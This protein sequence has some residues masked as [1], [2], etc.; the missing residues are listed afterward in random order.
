MIETVQKEVVDRTFL[1]ESDDSEE[2]KYGKQV[3]AKPMNLIRR[4]KEEHKYFLELAHADKEKLRKFIRMID[5]MT[6]QTLVKVNLQSMSILYEEMQ[7]DNRK[8]GGL[9][10]SMVRFDPDG[11]SF[12][13][14][15]KEI[16]E[17]LQGIL[18]DMIKV[19]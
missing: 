5:Y 13:P 16:A 9:F 11:I 6:I 3:K 19:A 18:T 2:A 4:Q 10:N 7:R 1:K 12:C 17:S 15:D 14:D 8:Q